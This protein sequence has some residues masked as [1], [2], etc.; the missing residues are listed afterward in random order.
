MLGY[1]ISMNM[2][3]QLGERGFQSDLIK[4]AINV[5]VSDIRSTMSTIKDYSDVDPAD[6]IDTDGN[7]YGFVNP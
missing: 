1:T 3:I 2:V 7:W 6:F 5:L 4:N